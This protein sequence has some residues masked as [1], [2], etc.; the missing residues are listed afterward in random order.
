MVL[1]RLGA[2][3]DPVELSMA[4]HRH[5]SRETPG[6]PPVARAER[7]RDRELVF[8][9][10]S[11]LGGSKTVAYEPEGNELKASK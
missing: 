1:Q 11:R 4:E 10:N 7:H 6:H 5:A 9:V 3:S 8:L 2:K